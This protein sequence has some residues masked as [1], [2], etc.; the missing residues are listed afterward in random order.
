[1][2]TEAENNKRI[3]KNTLLLYVRMLFMML[4][5]LYTSRVFLKTLG[6]QDYGI[7]NVVGGVIAMLG[8][9]QASL[10][11]ASS[12]FITFE[13][14]KG[15]K[16]TLKRTFGNIKSIH[17][18]FSGFILILGE[19]IGLWFVLN[20]LNIP[21]GREFAAFWVYQFSVLSSVVAILS[22]P[23]NAAIIAHEKMTAFAYISIFEVVAK[24]FIV[25][26]LIVIPF[27]KLIVFAFFAFLIQISSRI[28]YNV[29]S[30][31]HF[32]ETNVRLC[33]DKKLSKEIFSFAGWTM[34]GDLAVMGYTQGL[35]IILN[36]FFGPVV[37]AARSIAVQVCGIVQQFC[38]N[39]QL[40]LNPQITKSYAQGNLNYMHKLI[41]IS[42]KFCFFIV[43]FIGLP[44]II[45]ADQLLHW[46]LGVVPNHAAN[47]L[48]LI[49]ISSLFYTLANPIVIAVHATGKLKRFQI[50][51]GCMLLT[52]VPISYILLKY[53]SLPPEIVFIVH[54]VIEI[55]TQ[56]VRL[57][58]V[59]PMI[60]MDYRPYLYNVVFRIL[61]VVIVVPI[62]PLLIY[63][64]MPVNFYTFLFECVIC[65]LCSG[66]A[67]FF[68]GCNEKE[69]EFAKAKLSVLYGRYVK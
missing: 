2:T 20:K 45:E 55:L 62:L 32:E 5:G 29:Y 35:N 10:G 56:C 7:Y 38:W 68:L 37:N 6:V 23:Y 64:R 60:N 66:M 67:I 15:D 4:V 26:F 54:I 31:R 14:G 50:V 58:I 46:W 49:L 48:K 42:S 61:P 65:V 44:V 63:H 11:G 3:A 19:T 41:I 17:C 43:F 69:R 8:F 39:F 30:A 51:E 18:I 9:L 36:I 34:Y 13:L 52:I 57:Y 53:F 21:H 1:M 33:L 25:L 16:E 12:R 47:F 27:D 59:L 28:I 22:V 40:A 24:L